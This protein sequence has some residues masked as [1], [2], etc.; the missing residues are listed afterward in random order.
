MFDMIN[1]APDTISELNISRNDPHMLRTHYL[2]HIISIENRLIEKRA[3]N[4]LIDGLELIIRENEHVT[5][6]IHPRPFENLMV[7]YHVSSNVEHMSDGIG[8]AEYILS[9]SMQSETLFKQI[10]WIWFWSCQSA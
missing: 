6:W 10:F 8:G 5:N 1:S 3:W 2:P 7:A 9:A 4:K